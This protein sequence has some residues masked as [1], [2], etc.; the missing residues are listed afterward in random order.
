ME[1]FAA[2]GLDVAITELDI[3]MQLPSDAQK[4][5]QQ[6]K[7][8]AAV[9]KAC[10]AVSRCVGITFWGISDKHSWVP[11]FFPGNGDALPWDVNYHPKPA[12]AAMEAALK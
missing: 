4:L 7:D 3:R 2:L 12:V 6:A 1:R 10:Q 8:Y 11:G 5:A 9:A